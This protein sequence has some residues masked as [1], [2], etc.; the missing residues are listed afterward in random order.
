[1]NLFLQHLDYANDICLLSHK[2]YDIQ[3][4]IR[5]LEKSGE[6]KDQLRKTK[7]LNKNRTIEVAN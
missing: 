4:M 5:S 6:A 2:I 1:M 7:M 3:D